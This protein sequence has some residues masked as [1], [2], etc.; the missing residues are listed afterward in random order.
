MALAE[1]RGATERALYVGRLPDKSGH[2][3]P[4]GAPAGAQPR[5]AATALPCVC[6][7]YK[8]R[9]VHTRTLPV[10]GRVTEST[11]GRGCWGL[12]RLGPKMPSCMPIAPDLLS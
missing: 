10:V 12:A 1:A 5:R 7:P 8:G 11:A 9:T 6:N 2:S 4:Q 3:L